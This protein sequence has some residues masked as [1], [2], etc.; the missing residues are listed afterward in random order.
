M[1]DWGLKKESGV[2]IILC[3]MFDVELVQI[4]V[5]V[6]CKKKKLWFELKFVDLE[7]Y[8]CIINCM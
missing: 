8:I 7:L 4:F 3:Y 6:L 5:N 2:F 1:G